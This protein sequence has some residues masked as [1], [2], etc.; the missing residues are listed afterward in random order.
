MLSVCFPFPTSVNITC[1]RQAGLISMG[2]DSFAG[3]DRIEPTRPWLGLPGV[4]NRKGAVKGPSLPA[5]VSRGSAK[6]QHAAHSRQ[7]RVLAIDE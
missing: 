6:S 7:E 1:H 5:D 2:L 3:K 4:G